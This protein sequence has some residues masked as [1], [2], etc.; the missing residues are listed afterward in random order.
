MRALCSIIAG[1]FFWCTTTTQGQES[2][3]T[4]KDSISTL[5]NALFEELQ[6]NY[7][8]TKAK[9]WPAMRSYTLK[10]ALQNESLEASLKQ[11]T[12]L[13]DS[14]EG[15]HLI[16][17]SEKNWYGS[18]LG[19]PLSQ[20]QF[21]KST[22]IAYESNKPF[23]AKVIQKNYGYVYIPGMLLKDAT[24]EELDA[25]A[26]NIYDAILEIDNANDIKGWIIDVRL[27]VGGNSNVMLTGLYHLLGNG[28]T[29]LVLDIDK[30]VKTLSGLHEGV[31]YKNHKENNAVT[32]AAPPKPHI[33]VALLSGVLTNSA[34]EFVILGF[35]GRKNTIVIGEESYGNTTANDMYD[36]P[37]GIKA[38]ITESYGTDR[39]A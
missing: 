33:T 35:R 32:I 36:L 8:N 18:T 27:N 3:L 24:R 16:L 7:L 21:N 26:Q 14:I 17:F 30:H 13:F 15:N 10:E 28:R 11:A 29:H 12:K 4:T 34:G 38:A 6:E 22:L 25:A 1:C 19:K 37:F 39:S 9:D 23:E 20:E 5:Y 2:P 31:L